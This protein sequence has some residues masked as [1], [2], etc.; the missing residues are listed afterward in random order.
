MTVEVGP[1]GGIG[2]KVFAAMH[3]LQ[4]RSLAGLDDERFLAEPITHLREGMPKVL[5]IESRQW[6]HGS[7]LERGHCRY[8][9]WEH[10]Q[11]FSYLRRGV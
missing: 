9:G 8:R 4:Q 5:M 2:I 11:Q 10:G 6:V 1:D 7:G 3:I